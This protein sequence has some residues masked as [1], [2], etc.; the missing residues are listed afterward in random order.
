MNSEDNLNNYFTQAILWY[1]NKYLKPLNN[2]SFAACGLIII[3]LLLFALC[4][5]IYKLFPIATTLKYAVSFDNS[6]VDKKI[7]INPANSVEGNP[8]NSIARVLVENYVI[9][10]E[11]Y[12]YDRLKQQ[13]I[14]VNTNSTKAI[15]NQYYSFISIDNL[16]SPVLRYQDQIIR[17]IEPLIT[18]FN[19]NSTCDVQFRSVASDA[20]NNIIE[21]ML[22]QATIEF[23]IDPID[24]AQAPGTK[25]NFLVT[26]YKI[27]LLKN[28]KSNKN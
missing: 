2:R 26:S 5:Q 14:F 6:E 19:S 17:K 18:V 22:W 27:K 24:L 28:E 3:L 10:R 15:F 8:L 12:D 11:Q 20:D 7:K 1:N 9:Q 13:V 4:L 16:L 21:Q 25:F 23:K